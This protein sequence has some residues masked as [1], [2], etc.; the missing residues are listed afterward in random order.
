MKR[1]NM[2][3][4]PYQ[5]SDVIFE[6]WRTSGVEYLVIGQIADVGGGEFEFTSQLFDVFAGELLEERQ[7]KASDLRDIA[8]HISDKIYEKLTGVRGAFS[9]K[10]LYITVNQLTSGKVD[11]RLQIADADG[12]RP[13]TIQQSSEPIL[14]PA[15]S[16][17]GTK[18]AYAAFSQ[19]RPAIFIQDVASGRRE[20]VSS[21]KGINGAPDWSPD[22][23]FLAMT[24]SKDGNP[25]IYILELATKRWTRVT[26][27]YAIDTEPRWNPT[28]DYLIFTSNRGGSVQIYRYELAEQKVNRITYEGSYNARGDITQDGKYLVMV[29]RHRGQF[30]IATQDLEIGTVNILSETILDESPTIAPNGSMLIYATL[31]GDQ[32]ILSAVSFDGRVKFRIPSKRGD[33]REPAWSPF[34]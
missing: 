13:R 30:H 29:H 20:K 5:T 9:T 34:L 24:L 14:S 1:K 4:Q 21:S 25:E 10:L 31:E 16:P 22:G 2:L 3:S 7:G 26:D 27:H 12:H 28:G 19:R 23:R 32:G 8:H 18:I 33:V 6:E 15:W 11:F 17:D